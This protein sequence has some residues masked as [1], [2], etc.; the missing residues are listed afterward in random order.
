MI[1]VR[2]PNHLGDGVTALPAIH[3]LSRLD[4]VTVYAP[5]WGT[6]VYRDL[7]VEVRPRG[8]MAAA[9]TAV[10]FAP[11]LRAAW[12][13][14]RCRR[15]IGTATDFRHLLLTRRIRPDPVRAREYAALAE[16]AGARLEGPPT[17]QV[18]AS[19]VAALVPP[20]HIGIAPVSPS[21]AVRMWPGWRDLADRMERPVVFYGGPGE[22]AAV[23]LIAGPHAQV[24]G[25]PLGDFAATMTSC[26]LLLTND[27][28]L[29][30]FGRA[31]G[32]RVLTVFGSTTA[33]RT[34]AP[35]ALAVEGPDLPCRP[36][37]RQTCSVGGV[38]CLQ[39]EVDRVERAVL[40]ALDG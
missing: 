29:A 21:G 24:V 16:A 30:H 15:R 7:S 33:T 9:D 10:L 1:A 25:Q 18:R 11:S 35:G 4:A 14:R 31:A 2:A 22:E 28:G 19:D 39:I 8:T 36:C 20:G 34:G 13:A 12:Q 37:Y 5:G 26:A 40:G 23:Q 3:A 32:A 38:P 17:F 27:S 6:T